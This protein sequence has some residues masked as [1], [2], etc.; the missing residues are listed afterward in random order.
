M[1]RETAQR[2]DHVRAE[3][4]VRALREHGWDVAEA[5]GGRGYHLS[6]LEAPGMEQH[7]HMA[8]LDELERYAA[9]VARTKDASVVG[10][11]LYDRLGR[12]R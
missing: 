3:G 11:W 5:P 2:C 12:D 10:A 6:R 8:D 1:D 4:A 7:A 9:Y